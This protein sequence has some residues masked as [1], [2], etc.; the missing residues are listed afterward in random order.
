M[1]Y[2]YDK[3]LEDRDRA[4]EGMDRQMDRM[5][6]EMRDKDAEN[7]ELKLEIVRLQS[8]LLANGILY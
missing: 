8:L 3:E 2:G 4:M 5:I 7:K 1:S 6:Y